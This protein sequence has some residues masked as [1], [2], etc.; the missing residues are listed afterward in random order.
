MLE[1]AAPSWQRAAMNTPTRSPM[2][3]GF[4]ICMS[5]FIGTAIGVHYRQISIGFLA[6]LGVGIALALAIWLRDRRR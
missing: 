2:A 6:G 4:L 1:S 5:I 3:G